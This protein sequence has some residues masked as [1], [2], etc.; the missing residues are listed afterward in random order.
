M[1]TKYKIIN[2]SEKTTA[3]QQSNLISELKRVSG[4]DTAIL[5][6][7]SKEM[8]IKPLETHQPIFAELTA[9]VV[10]AGFAMGPKA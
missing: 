1:T 9:A 10:K 7:A 5:H 8:E 2:L 4:V 6:L 3:D